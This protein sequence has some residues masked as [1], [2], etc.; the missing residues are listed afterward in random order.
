MIIRLEVS[1]SPHVILGP[2]LVSY[3]EFLLLFSLFC[4]ICIVCYLSFFQFLEFHHGTKYIL[5]GILVTE[6]ILHQFVNPGINQHTGIIAVTIAI[7]TLAVCLSSILQ[8]A[9]F[10]FSRWGKYLRILGTDFWHISLH[11]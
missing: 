1:L 7:Q 9:V 4:C 8:P 2:K 5:G 11:P 3:I 6:C 10:I